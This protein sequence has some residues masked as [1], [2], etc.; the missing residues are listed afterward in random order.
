MKKDRDRKKGILLLRWTAIIVTS[1]L[2]LFSKGRVT[3]LHLS[4]LLIFVYIF[5]NFL[6][7]LVPKTW[8]SN[9]KVFLVLI[10]FIRTVFYG[11]IVQTLTKEKFQELTISE[12]KYRGLFENAND[13][14]IILR[15]PQFQIADVNR[16]RR[17]E[18]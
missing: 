10:D 3:D 11:Y 8:F 14:I 7:I 9:Q 4:H 5:S 13:M 17:E 15:N 18:S 2:I 12:D 16:E 1:Y 6:L